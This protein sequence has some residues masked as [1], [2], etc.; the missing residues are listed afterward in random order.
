MTSDG[1]G[2]TGL[3]LFVL[4][5]LVVLLVVIIAVTVSRR[6]RQRP[7]GRKAPGLGGGGGHQPFTHP[8]LDADP[9]GGWGD[10]PA[11]SP[12]R[13]LAAGLGA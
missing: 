9:P 13:E 2:N 8:R 4:A 12:G 3:G 7:P 10:P 11:G 5:L 1:G 6:A